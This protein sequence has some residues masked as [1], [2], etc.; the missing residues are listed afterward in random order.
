MYGGTRDTP[1]PRHTTIC[2]APAMYWYCLHMYGGKRD[3]PLPR[4][5]TICCTPSMYW[6]CVHMSTKPHGETHMVGRLSF[7]LIT[8]GFSFERSMLLLHS[9]SVVL[10][11]STELQ[12]HALLLVTTSEKV[13]LC[14]HSISKFALNQ[15]QLQFQTASGAVQ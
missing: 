12:Y 1:L 10:I 11:R 6:Y 13:H 15:Q 14:N 8:S 4:H 2:H 7:F 5:M 9:S 3:T